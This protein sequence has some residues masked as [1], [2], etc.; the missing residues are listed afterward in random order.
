MKKLIRLLIWMMS[1]VCYTT[2]VHA[3]LPTQNRRHIDSGWQFVRGDLGSIWEVWRP[4][5]PGK[6]QAVPLWKAVTLPHCFNDTDACD[7]DENYYQGP[8]W[9]RTLLKLHNPYPG[10]RTILEFE[11]AGT[12]DR[13]ICI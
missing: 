2:A 13:S 11:G 9:Y 8:G 1:T 3:M 5:Q 4:V 12:K 10:G 7:P 6:P